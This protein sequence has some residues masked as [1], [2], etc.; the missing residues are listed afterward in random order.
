MYVCMKVCAYAIF[1]TDNF[2]CVGIH[3]KGYIFGCVV[4]H[5]VGYNAVILK[6]CVNACNLPTLI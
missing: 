5:N 2:A 3:S 6:I 4:M 1:N